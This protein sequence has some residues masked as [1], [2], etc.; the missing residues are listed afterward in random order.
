MPKP[1]NMITPAPNVVKPGVQ[2]NNSQPKTAT[3]STPSAYQQ[4]LQQPLK[5]DKWYAGDYPTSREMLG[6]I[7][8]IYQE[9]REYG[10]KMLDNFHAEQ[11]NSSSRYYNPYS[12]TTN[13]AVQ[14]L[15]NLGVDASQINDEWY[16]NN[17]GWQNYLKF[18]GTTNTPISPGKRASVQEKIAFEIYQL[19]KADEDTKKMKSEWDAMKD[20]LSYWANRSDL[21]LSDDEIVDRVTKEMQSKYPTLARMQE[22]MA[23]GK[24]LL[25]LNEGSDFSVD[26]MYG[27]IWAARNGG[28]VGSAE[29]NT[30]LSALGNGNVWNDNPQIRG[31]L[32][33][34]DKNTYSPYSVGM[35]LDDAGLYFGVY[36]FDDDVLEKIRQ[37]L[38]PNDQTALKY[39]NEAV[40]ANDTTNKAEEELNNLTDKV[41][42][43]LKQEKSQEF[44]LKQVDKWLQQKEFSTL[45]AMDSSM[46][47]GSELL[48]TSRPINYRKQDFIQRINDLFADKEEKTT[49][50]DLAV[51]GVNP[52]DGAVPSVRAARELDEYTRDASAVFEDDAT[53]EEVAAFSGYSGSHD[54]AKATLTGVRLNKDSLGGMDQILNKQT[55]KVVGGYIQDTTAV[56]KSITDYENAQLQLDEATMTAE[57]LRQQLGAKEFYGQKNNLSYN[58]EI[59]GVTYRVTMSPDFNYISSIEEYVH[60]PGRE[61]ETYPVYDDGTESSGIWQTVRD[62]EEFTAHQE[63]FRN[64]AEKIAEAEGLEITEQDEN[65]LKALRQADMQIED[66]EKYL[67]SNKDQYEKDVASYQSG[68]QRLEAHR[69]NLVDAGA[70]TY[71][72]DVAI[73]VMQE[74][75]SF[76]DYEATVWDQ[77]NPTYAYTE[78]IASGKSKAEVME[79]AESDYREALECIKDIEWEKK[80]IADHH[81]QIPDNVKQ[82]MDRRLAKHQRDIQ[83]YEFFKTQWASDFDA[84]VTEQRHKEYDARNRKSL[85]GISTPFDGMSEEEYFASMENNQYEPEDYGANTLAGLI[86]DMYGLLTRDE[87]DTYYYLKA[88][89]KENGTNKSADYLNF[90]LDPTYGVLWTR[91]R[92]KTEEEAAN[93]TSSGVGGFVAANA[94]SVLLSPYNAV[95]S[96][97]MWAYNK[98]TGRELNPNSPLLMASHF[99]N[100]TR[101]Q[102]AQEILEAFGEKDEKGNYKETTLSKIAQGGYEILTNRLD[103]AM[104]AAAFGWM[105][106]GVGNEMLQEFLSAAPMGASA[107]MEAAA[108]AKERGASDAQAYAIATWTFFAETGTEAISLDNMKNALSIGEEMGAHT[109]KEFAL[110][111]LKDAGISEAFGESLNDIIEKCADEKIMGV[112]SEHA[113]AVEKYRADGYSEIDAEAMARRDEINDV[114]RT[115][116]ISYLSP[117]LDVFQ[118][119]KGRYNYYKGKTI[120]WNKN[121][122]DNKKTFREIRD[123]IRQEQKG[124]READRRQ[125]EEWE[126]RPVEEMGD[127]DFDAL[128]ERT[129]YN[130]TADEQRKEQ[131]AMKKQQAESY[132]VDFEIL[133]S[134]KEGGLS[135]QKAG[136]SAVLDVENT[137]ES[138]DA[139][140][141]AAGMLADVLGDRNAV[142][143][144]QDLM[145]GANVT[146]ANIS[147]E[148]I[149]QGIMYAALG[150]EE[151]ACRQTMQSDE[152]QK[153]TP[154]VKA[155]ML[156]QAVQEDQ[157]NKKVNSTMPQVVHNY[158][159]AVEEA[160]LISEGATKTI[161]DAEAKAIETEGVTLE[162]QKKLDE[163]RASEK[164]AFEAAQQAGLYSDANTHQAK[165][166]EA[167][168]QVEKRKAY[169]AELAAAQRREQAAKEKARKTSQQVKAQI[170]QQAEANVAQQ[171]Q[172]RQQEAEQLR[173]AQE[174]AA[175]EQQK[176]KAELAEQERQQSEQE[177]AEEQNTQMDQE[178][179]V[180]QYL[181]EYYSGD[182][183]ERQVS[184]VMGYAEQKARRSENMGTK[185]SEQDG[186]KFLRKISRMT[187]ITYEMQD[188]GD[189][190]RTRGKIIDRQHMVLNSNL[191]KGQALVEAA[192]HEVTHGLEETKAY[193][194]YAS[195]VLNAMYGGE[196]TEKYNEA[197]QRKLDEYKEEFQGL[198]PEE[199]T[200]R[201]KYELVAEYA[202]LNLAKKEFVRGIASN[203]LAGKMRDLI[204]NAIAMLKGY[205]LDAEGKAKYQELRTA[206]KLL[207][208]AVNERAEHIQESNNGH[209]GL[210][211][212]SITGWTD[213][214]GLTLEVTDDDS[215]V[216]K[217]KYNGEEIKPGE[218]KAEMVKGTP[219]GNLIDMAAKSRIDTLTNKLN[220]GKISQKEYNAQLKQLADTSKQQ[221]EYV[222]QIINM[223]GQYQ[224]AAMVWELAG[225]LAFSSLKTNGDPQYSDSYDFGTICTK[226]QAILNAIS[227]TQVDLGRALTKEEIDGIV[228]EEVGKGVQKD[229]KWVHG[230][231]PCPPCY[232]YA[233]WVN[234]PAR[235]EKVR[236]YQNECAN[237]T[238]EQIND[239]MNQPDPKGK[240]ATETKELKTEQNSK[241]LWISLCLADEKTDQNT[242]KKTWVR[243]ENP[244]ICP[245]EILLDLRR[246]GD[247]ATQH[248]G[249]WAFMQK[250]GN[251]QGK[252]IAPYSDA[253]LGE[254]IVAKAIGAGEAGARMLE[255]ERNAGNAEYIPQFLNPFLSTDANDQEKAKQYFDKAV[256]EIKK[257]NLKGGQ[258]WQSW[259]DFRAE[260][261]SDYLMEMITMQALGS[262][263]QTYT[264]VVEALDLL[265][266]AGFEVNM[267]LM[268]YGDGFWH[269]EDGSIMIDEDGNMKLRFS[270][271]T[272][273]NPDAAEEFAKKYGEK[274]N[275]QPMV[276]GIS[277]EHIKAALAGNYITFVI[278]FH[279]SGGSVKRLQHLMSLLHEQMESG[280][281]YTKAQSDKFESVNENGENTNPNWAIREKILTGEYA[282]ATDEQIDEL[283]NKPFLKKLYEDRYINED[284]DAFGVFFNKGEAQQIYPYEYWDTNTTLATA[285]KNSKRFIDYCQMLGVV[286]RFSGLTKTE[287]KGK[288]ATT[289]E[290]ANFSGRSVGK[291]G[292]VTYE[293]VKGYWKL[294]IDRSMY[295]RVYDENGKIVPEKCKYHKPQ[296]VSTADINI[297]AM[298]QAANNTVG[299]SDDDTRE[300]VERII[301]RLEMTS[302]Q[303]EAAGSAVDLQQNAEDLNKAM[304]EGSDLEQKSNLGDLSDAEMENAL[305]S[306]NE[307]YA[308]AIESGDM[309]TAQR[310][311]DEKAKEA[312]YTIKA[313]HGT[314]NSGHFTV[315]DPKK[316]NNTKLSSY[317]G[318]GFY[319]TNSESGARE[320]MQNSDIN[321]RMTAGRDPH[322]FKGY[323]KLQ[324]PI[325]ITEDSHNVPYD[326]VRDIIADGDKA[327]FFDNG[328]A[329][330]LQNTTING[331]KYTKEEISSMSK[332]EKID[333][334][335]RHLVEKGDR[336]ALQHMV[337][338]YSYGNQDLLLESMKN[339]TGNDGIHWQ[340][341][342]GLDQFVVFDSSQFKESDTVTYDDSGNVIPL[343][344]RFSDSN[345]IRY[346]RRGDL[347]DSEMENILNGYM[348]RHDRYSAPLEGENPA[349]STGLGPKE[350][351]FGSANGMLQRSDEV[352]RFAKASTALLNTYFPDTNDAQINRAI[353]WIGSLKQTPNSDGYAEALQAVT[354]DDFDYR[355][356]DGQA[357]MVAVMGMANAR[358]DAMAQAALAD[359]FDRQGTDIGRMMQARKLF[360]L[361]TPEGR[362]QTLWNMLKRQQA[363]LGRRGK[364]I[365]LKF[366]DWIYQAAAA[367][368][369]EE[370][371]T[372]VRNAAI[373]ELAEQIP[374]NWRDRI[375]SLRMLSMLANPRTHIRNI[376]GNMMFVPAVSLKNKLGA[377]G[378]IV[379]GQERTKTLAVASSKE[380]RNFARQDA[381]NIKSLLTGEAKYNEATLIR[382]AQSKLGSALDWMS[383]KNSNA[384]EKEDWIFLKGHYRRALGGWMTANGY[385]VEQVQNDRALL[386]KGREYAI[387]EAQKA[388]YRDFN[389]TAQTLNQISRKGGVAGFLV[390][391]VLPFKKTPAN[392]LKRGLEY[393]PAGIVKSLTTDMY[394]MKQ[395]LDYQNGKLKVLPNKALSPTQVIDHICSG[396]SGTAIT[397]LGFL[398]AGTGAV[399]CGL[400]DDE[401]KLEK[402]KGGQEYAVN[403]GKAGNKILGIFG[404]PKL[405]GEDVTFTM[406]WAAPMSMPFFVGAAIRDQMEQGG[407]FNLDEVINAFGNI[408][409]PVF[410]LSMLDGINTLFKTSQYDDTNT[411]TQIGA[412]VLTN[413]ATSYVPSVLGAISRTFFD[414]KQRK[415]FV[416]QGEG[417]GFMGTI[418]YAVEQAENKIPGLAQTNIA[419]RDIWGEEK[420]SSFAERLFENFILPGYI[421][422]IEDDPILNEVGR[423]FDVT[424]DSSMIPKE[425]PDKSITVDKEKRV[426][427]DKQWDQYK[428]V[429]NQTAHRE[430]GELINS[431]EYNDPRTTDNARAQMVKDVWSHADKI[432]RNAVFPDYEVESKDVASIAK[433]GKIAGLKNELIKALDADDYEAY[434]AMVEAIR[435]EYDDE[436]D[437]DAA[438]KKKIG[439]T[440]RDQW[441][442]A[443]RMS[444]ETRMAEI[445]DILEYSEY[446]FNIYGKG[447]WQ[448]KVDEKYGE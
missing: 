96:G 268:P 360:M 92:M 411:I 179:Y 98:I 313:Y 402:A 417:T 102:S 86:G 413:Y 379:T 324:N 189:P 236:V 412:K 307:Q 358:N 232:V 270:P 83:D 210:V 297:G 97:A 91:R 224:D 164:A 150:G 279:G 196:N 390:D 233:T 282:N 439:D 341:H 195:F 73:A 253:R 208:K 87:Q 320:Y 138:K 26:N 41:N 314:A 312:G 21:N 241:K 199:A 55:D 249:T 137:A 286:P 100:K 365:D 59:N 76:T 280:N 38:D 43:L 68:L 2:T 193:K 354:A 206:M 135:A 129:G 109:F 124:K 70:D 49:A 332:D 364:N 209:T 295:H 183:L 334:Y 201:A 333:L 416:K 180:R 71:D 389:K 289:V 438:I 321:G 31:K 240:T 443:Y 142:T 382:K 356:A 202:R 131:I 119:V 80:Y 375:R 88:K 8:S 415:S 144:V 327:W 17:P 101:E 348:K 251:A 246:S 145:T 204:S 257:Q 225:S 317:I 220:R 148:T 336:Y 16:K 347:S 338:A 45:R 441:K 435:E 294:L 64:K 376:I 228:Y 409:E 428:A 340:M 170:R 30:M 255:D 14:N 335:A 349:M 343:S 329:H 261:G 74:L 229:G 165:L 323:I 315:F 235:L 176:Q 403:L 259:S 242:G 387:Q 299:H 274:G 187:G 120:E 62:S 48:Q 275:V 122:P 82:N 169:E 153:A 168:K 9:D 157:Q 419:V 198:S 20:E 134:A 277:D 78:A 290:Y 337:D 130:L 29:A 173:I 399:S 85:L 25:E 245:N 114:L 445:E 269:N 431:S 325:E 106:S 37:G 118:T 260:W 58:T 296:A 18:N 212:A 155:S 139:A 345:D 430:L 143:E 433:D 252:A 72:V 244:D 408:T 283:E 46:E 366:S 442:K 154:A 422:K 188:L 33:W 254:S 237:W 53:P 287:G 247:M 405:F 65:M 377:I 207:N 57:T 42:G 446:D 386:E 306:A 293:P 172:Q 303:N 166:G 353:K 316:L 427:T 136:I 425:D 61:E 350:R 221:R 383:E 3:V 305:R 447:G 1:T 227:Q 15:A 226:T 152:Y 90:M 60:V 437:A 385:T 75:S 243:K 424:G 36:Y 13:R 238:N 448:E 398:L 264:K 391:A 159:V 113:E 141:A 346:S 388:T 302:G 174:Q 4:N 397:A 99:R 407:E 265:A 34:N 308:K 231:T 200:E 147:Q 115:A 239:F 160:R 205:T 369:N 393:S 203:G 156:A 181:S 56:Y 370:D 359:A 52:S 362:K 352:G 171:D 367:A 351:A 396:L 248:P 194:N 216:Y 81:I 149:K 93:L 401:D 11:Q 394:H 133:E 429:R 162:A 250:G 292:K 107:A 47:N 230:A 432:G 116:M 167:M 24:S 330:D 440:Y 384:L 79:Q 112:L 288:N 63:E 123:G 50:A 266:S 178:Q 163:Q 368:T 326:V 192:L 318:Q 357:R 373:N 262:Q 121:N 392:I 117:G 214:T 127:I 211:Q 10:Q 105:F 125:Q 110:H 361:M 218:Y 161:D 103:S 27:T 300:I 301:Q 44:I 371:M 372:K 421:S 404:A 22:S 342:D 32:N 175:A 310:M 339:H 374:A 223:I 128:G 39:Y 395:Y 66:A 322:L 406:D 304:Y 95:S 400:D 234:K 276:V 54:A 436:A 378:E 423:L 434:D 344:E 111:W 328:I 185:L 273:I 444:D 158:R 177:A 418:R 215:H 23:P 311:V 19:G 69:Q 267:S 67:R 219:V 108:R 182:E 258:R 184:R 89:D 35:T 94:V 263:V 298:P 40:K 197:M 291:D 5:Q 284:S 272:G 132:A 414:D 191:T 6:K 319:F 331:Q 151:S 186:S 213:A 84:V 140:D 363:E 222:A 420:T 217:L 355:S 381:E 126:S 190:M 309:E 146:N 410:N 426:L 12:A 51:N 28:G 271:V 285:D 380:V 77:Y 278:P 7:Y 104:N 281:D 256:R